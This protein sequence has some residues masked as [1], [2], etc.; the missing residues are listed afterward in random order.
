MSSN[1]SR[2]FTQVGVDQLVRLKWLEQT[3]SLVLAGNDDAKIKAILQADLKDSF[4]SD[5]PEVRAS[6]V[7]L[8][9]IEEDV[10]ELPESLS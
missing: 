9:R 7:L 5:N 2:R 3:A 6:R 10:L 4:R 8:L 1:G